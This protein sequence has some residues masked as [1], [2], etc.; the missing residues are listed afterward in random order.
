VSDSEAEDETARVELSEQYRGRGNIKS[1]KCSMVSP[2]VAQQ[3]VL[4]SDFDPVFTNRNSLNW[5]RD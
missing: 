5:D 4:S 3:N 1:Q 2:F